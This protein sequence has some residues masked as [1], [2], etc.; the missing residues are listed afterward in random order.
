M[1]AIPMLLVILAIVLL[2]VVGF[3]VA[4]RSRRASAWQRLSGAL[5]GGVVATGL[6]A[7]AAY[8]SDPAIDWPRYAL[9]F[10]YP[11]AVALVVGILAEGTRRLATRRSSKH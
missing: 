7:G 2:P 4:G 3:R 6:Y 5:V 10:A 8:L 9:T 1:E 11:V